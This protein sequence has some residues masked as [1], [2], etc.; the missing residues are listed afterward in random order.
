LKLD[1]ESVR[2][3]DGSVHYVTGDAEGV[4]EKRLSKGVK[5]SVSKESL[6]VLMKVSSDIRI[7]DDN[8][9]LMAV[10]DDCRAV[11]SVLRS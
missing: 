9:R 11:M 1:C 6:D 10:A 3:E 7:S 4:L 2:F 5:C 8:N